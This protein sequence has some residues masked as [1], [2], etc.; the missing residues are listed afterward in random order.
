MQWRTGGGLFNYH[1]DDIEIIY[2]TGRLS[3][4]KLGIQLRKKKKK[5]RRMSCQQTERMWQKQSLTFLVMMGLFFFSL[6]D[7]F[8]VVISQKLMCGR[9]FANGQ[10]TKDIDNC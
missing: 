10:I 7:I 8:R 1:N 6:P 3:K 9:I 4:D 2:T 5:G